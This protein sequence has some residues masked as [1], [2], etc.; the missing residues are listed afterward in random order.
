M[1]GRIRG[2]PSKDAGGLLLNR[3]CHDRFCGVTQSL[4][5]AEINRL[6]KQTRL[7]HKV[8]EEVRELVPILGDLESLVA[9]YKQS[10]LLAR[11][12]LGL[13]DPRE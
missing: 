3:E 13:Y 4:D 6:E 10:L 2:P 11:D 7:I 12:L 1:E 8:T 9:N 5:D